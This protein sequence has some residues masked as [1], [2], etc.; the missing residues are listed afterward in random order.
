MVALPPFQPIETLPGNQDIASQFPAVERSFRDIM[1]SWVAFE[2]GRSG[3]HAFKTDTTTN[4]DADST[5]EV[6]S[7]FLNTTLGALQMV[8]SIGPVVFKNVGEFDAGT[9]VVLQQTSAP[10]GYTKEAGA[11]YDNATLKFFTGAVSNGGATGFATVFTATRTA[12]GT[13]D[14]TVLTAAN[15]PTGATYAKANTNVAFS[16][17]GT[18]ITIAPNVETALTG[19]ANSAHTHPFTSGNMDFNVKFVGCAVFQKDTW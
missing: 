1:E 11:A 9:R 10:T 13:T 12:T 17:G 7:L 6:G 3:H 14:G 16:L 5:W 4:R 19:A 2:H 8:K 15:M 18:G